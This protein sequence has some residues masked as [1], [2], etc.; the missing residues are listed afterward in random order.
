MDH[1]DPDRGYGIYDPGGTNPVVAE[2]VA[3]FANVDPASFS[4]SYPVDT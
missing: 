1:V 4:Y 2:I 3:E